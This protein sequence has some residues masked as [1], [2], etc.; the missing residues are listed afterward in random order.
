MIKDGSAPKKS[1]PIKVPKTIALS[2]LLLGRDNY[3]ESHKKHDNN[4][5]TSIIFGTHF[6]RKLRVHKHKNEAEVY[7]CPRCNP[8][9]VISSKGIITSNPEKQ[10]EFEQ[11]LANIALYAITE[12]ANKT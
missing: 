4:N 2:K 12:Y 6:Q 5:W 8:G 9:D 3:N 10:A 7:A 1:T 11:E